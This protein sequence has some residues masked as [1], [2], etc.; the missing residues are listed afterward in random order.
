MRRLVTISVTVLG[1]I[2]VATLAA[3]GGGAIWEF[4][5]YHEPGER[6]ETATAVAWGTESGTPDDGPYYVYLAPMDIEYVWPEI[7]EEALLVGVVEIREGPLWDG[8]F[9]V[10]PHHAVARFEIPDVAPG[11]YQI[12]HCND[13]CTTGLGDIIGG[14]DLRIL[15]GSQ[16]RAPEEVADDARESVTHLPL[17]YPQDTSTIVSDGEAIPTSTVSTL[18]VAPLEAAVAAE[19]EVLRQAMENQ[20]RAMGAIRS[21]QADIAQSIEE[22]ASSAAD[23]T[24]ETGTLTSVLLVVAGFGA[25]VALGWMLTL[26]WLRRQNETGV[27]RLHVPSESSVG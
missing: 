15:A 2:W 9:Y 27:D 1:L 22:L 24:P 17:F 18:D 19:T 20:G 23:A 4:E 12:L 26:A 6:V 13:P 25:G 11:T 5:G 21:T 8:Q 3:A 16:G 10:G 7:P 14:W